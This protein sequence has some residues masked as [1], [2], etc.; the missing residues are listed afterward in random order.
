MFPRIMPLPIFRV[1]GR[2]G[3][4]GD[5]AVSAKRLYVITTQKAKIRIFKCSLNCS[6]FSRDS[7]VD[8]FSYMGEK[9]G[10]V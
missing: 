5:I 6:F 8:P 1:M 7:V 4:G 9:P 10:L 2:A 3:S